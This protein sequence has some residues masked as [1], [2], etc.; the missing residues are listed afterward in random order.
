MPFDDDNDDEPTK[1]KT[2]LKSQGKSIFDK[3]PKKPSVQEF[4]RE[5]SESNKRLD[6][7]QEQAKELTI[8]FKK[9]MDDKTLQQ[10]KNVFAADIENDII[11]KMIGLAVQINQDK[12]EMEGMGSVGW[13][14]LLLKHTFL[15]KD[16]INYLEYTVSVQ[17][18][19]L[20]SHDETIKEILS[21]LVEK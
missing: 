14:A 2:G 9:L 7:Y 11:S 19:K 13:I 8:Q 20:K 4:E 21:K 12:D 16:R 17:D 18:N 10:N 15:L 3:M 6:S 5:A 1:P